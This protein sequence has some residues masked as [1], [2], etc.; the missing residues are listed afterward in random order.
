MIAFKWR[1]RYFCVLF[2]GAMSLFFLGVCPSS[3]FC[4]E[5]SADL[6]GA[7]AKSIQDIVLEIEIA[8]DVA[9]SELAKLPNTIEFEKIR[10][11]NELDKWAQV[12]LPVLLE[13]HYD[14]VREGLDN[15]YLSSDTNTIEI[16]WNQLK[17]G[18]T[19]D[20]DLKE[21]ISHFVDAA[22]ENIKPAVEAFQDAIQESLDAHL[23]TL[24]RQ[25]MERI[26]FSFVAVVRENLP[27]YATIPLPPIDIVG[28]SQTIK[29]EDKDFNNFTS[30][31]A[32]V[33]GV[34]LTVL[35]K[36][37]I[38]KI[39]MRIMARVSGKVLSKIIPLVG[40]FLLA[41]EGF[42]MV[43][44]KDSLEKELRS[45]FLKEYRESLTVQ[46]LWF[47][48]T[49]QESFSMREELSK[50]IEENLANWRKICDRES[51]SMIESARILVSSPVFRENVG[52]EIQKGRDFEEVS[53]RLKNLWNIFG[54]LI[55]EEKSM[56]FF[57]GAIAAAPDKDELRIL[58]RAEKMRF[59]SSYE[60]FGEDY[61]QGVHRIGLNNYLSTG[62][63][64]V[65]V[66]WR[67][68]NKRLV[69]VPDIGTSLNAA[70]GLLV[71]YSSDVPLEFFTPQ[72]MEQI[73]QREELF[74]FMWGVLSRD[75]PKK[76]ASLFQSEIILGKI[77]FVAEG[78]PEIAPAYLKDSSQGFWSTWDERDLRD[79]MEISSY[80]LKNGVSAN[81]L[82]VSPEDRADLLRTYRKAGEPGL[83]L[84]DVYNVPGSGSVG[85][86]DAL[87]AAN[88][89][90][91]GYP[92]EDL[93][94]KDTFYF[95]K[96][97]SRVPVVGKFFFQTFG[98]LS[99]VVRTS[100]LFGFL[101]VVALV[102][103]RVFSRRQNR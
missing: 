87:E 73:G 69:Y 72:M 53:Q 29:G 7:E 71:L 82:V 78:Y 48:N 37:I 31:V 30:I 15:T 56:Y 41:L 66:D 90:I 102:V 76:I 13:K 27:V 58:A 80:R 92:L 20:D 70:K 23:T 85:R 57:E 17:A 77:A 40:I 3:V 65:D 52:R 43:Q 16:W 28:V 91:K 49:G 96:T 21:D 24:L 47:G 5:V 68:L 84:W 60:E 75:E 42:Q 54:D 18:V 2:W 67:L 83:I 12:V 94:S 25:S 51:R 95:A 45:L 103:L 50:T 44:A 46:S 79:L 63:R 4:E 9:M 38:P 33:V 6:N 99:V 55:A 100:L 39:M 93:E 89:F 98:G 35:G 64:S 74:S 1:R 34:V 36:R 14:H 26:R 101:F 10:I 86:S 97:C 62:W 32:V 61:L 8:S 22:E 19:L 11:R 81:D 59:L 88:L